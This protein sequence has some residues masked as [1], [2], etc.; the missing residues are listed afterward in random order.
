MSKN[1][2]EPVDFT[3]MFKD[4]KPVVH[5][6]YV[7]P[8]DERARRRQSE[9][10]LAK[11]KNKLSQDLRDS[12]QLRASVELS[13]T[14]EGHWPENKPIKYINESLVN[15]ANHS[16]SLPFII[17]A[18]DMLKKLSLGYFPPDIE[19][20]LHGQT[21]QQAKAEIL[22]VIFEAKKRHY[23][24]INI[25]H[26]HGKGT[27]KHKVPNW[28]VQHPDVAGFVQAPRNYGGK[29]GLLVLIGIDFEA[30]KPEM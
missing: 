13:D 16:D 11:A 22:A 25:I 24:C 9:N 20:D 26:G 27:L 29:A 5:D 30:Y 17:A 12:A 7:A 14:F 18:K 23:P 2:D 8:I 3:A 4:A 15:T 21:A 10:K 1:N 6:R 28:L 19:I